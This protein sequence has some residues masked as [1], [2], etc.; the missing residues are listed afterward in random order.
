MVIFIVFRDRWSH[1]EFAQ[2]DLARRYP[3]IVRIIESGP[4]WRGRRIVS[5]NLAMSDHLSRA[6]RNG[7]ADIR[8]PNSSISLIRLIRDSFGAQVEQL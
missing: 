6:R 2:L 3:Q 5:A 4:L 1:G 7:L 8:D